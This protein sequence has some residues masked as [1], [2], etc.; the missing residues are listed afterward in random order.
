MR[1]I[2]RIIVHCTATRPEWMK[3]YT[4]AVKAGEIR[5]WHKEKGWSDIGY[6]YLIDRNGAWVLG[7]DLEFAGAH[8]RRENADS[9]GVA[10]FGG[11]GAT[12]TD[13]F[14][15]HFTSAQSVM[16]RKTISDMELQYG[17]LGVHGHNE[18]AAKG[19]PGFNVHEW[20]R[21]GN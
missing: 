7:R 16:L 8:T 20:L 21:S 18:Y 6:H 10:L 12:K 14:S 4:A 3:D 19:C 15:D 13:T 5:R 9:I 1:K 2:N 17:P 11:Y